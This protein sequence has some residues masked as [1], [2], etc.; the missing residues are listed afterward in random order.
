MSKINKILEEL[1]KK[2]EEAINLKLEED[3]K[4]SNLDINQYYKDSLK[5]D[6]VTDGM[7]ILITE[8]SIKKRL[9]PKGISHMKIVQEMLDQMYDKHTDLSSVEGDYGEVIPLEYNCVFI[10]MASPLNGPTIIY[11]PDFCNEYQISKLEKFNEQIKL[12]DKGKIYFEYR[13][14]TTFPNENIDEVITIVK[15][16]LE[17]NNSM[18]N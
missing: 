7:V 8:N 15:N 11:Y 10:R 5:L 4:R 16:N 13:N 1:K 9:S 14:Q 3:I 2:R 17:D 12:F 18:K 6:N